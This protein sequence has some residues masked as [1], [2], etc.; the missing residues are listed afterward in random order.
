GLIRC[1]YG[2][3]A[4]Y[5]CSATNHDYDSRSGRE[6]SASSAV[7][8]WYRADARCCDSEVSNSECATAADDH[9]AD[10]PAPG[11]QG[12]FAGAR[13]VCGGRSSSAVYAGT[14]CSGAANLPAY[15]AAASAGIASDTSS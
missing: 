13:R 10:R 11:L 9:A 6:R 12:A 8:L 4:H 3:I 1:D 5:R 2:A 14:T 15:G 7:S